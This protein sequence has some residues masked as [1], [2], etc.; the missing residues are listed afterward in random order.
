MRLK[1]CVWRIHG[2]KT[3]SLTTTGEYYYNESFM[4]CMGEKCPAFNKFNISC[5]KDGCNFD[6][7][8]EPPKEEKTDV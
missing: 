4:P 8:P 3:M 5:M 1:P 6:L 7:I 2:E